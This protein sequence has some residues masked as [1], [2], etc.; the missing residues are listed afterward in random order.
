MFFS[1]LFKRLPKQRNYVFC[2][3][4]IEERLV[5][6]A[7]TGDTIRIVNRKLSEDHEDKYPFEVTTEEI[8]ENETK[9]HIIIHPVKYE[10][11]RTIIVKNVGIDNG[12]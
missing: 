9:I 5:N 7:L 3:D 11:S 10:A 12:K 2:I 8:S 4:S 6:Y 1:K